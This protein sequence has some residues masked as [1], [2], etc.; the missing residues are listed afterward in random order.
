[1]RVARFAAG[2][3]VSYGLVGTARAGTAAGDGEVIAELAGHP[4]GGGRD[5]IRLTGTT[6]QLADARLLA[7]VLPSKVIGFSPFG[8][9]P[10]GRADD[11]LDDGSVMYLKPSTAVCGPSDAV[12][13]PAQA[14]RLVAEGKLAVII[15]RLCRQ[16]PPDQA[17]AVIFGY[18]CA[19]D[20]TAVGLLAGDGQWARAKGFDTFCP[21]GPWI[22]TGAAGDLTLVTSVNGQV[23]QR[24]SIPLGGPVVA[25][26]IAEASSVMTLLPG[27]VL[28][29]GPAGGAGDEAAPLDCGDEV[30]VSID[31]IGTLTNKVE[32]GD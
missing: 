8:A 24:A 5:G 27:D 11:G 30:S 13:Y 31:A 3:E 29:A 25:A 20:V 32:K 19:L 6:Y 12:R 9:G 17:A 7:P 1:V 26:L 22:E 4:F 23:R 15:G 18:A 10:A 14:Q 2:D 21:R 28:L 16:V